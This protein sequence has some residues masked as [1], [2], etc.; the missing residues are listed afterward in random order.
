M[1]GD[2]DN[3]PIWPE[4]DVYIGTLAAV[5]PTD[6]STAWGSEWSVL[7]L[8]NGEE[9][10]TETREQE[11]TNHFA[12]GGILI[13]RIRSQHQRTFTIRALE[14]NPV[15]FSLVNPGSPEPTTDTAGLTTR[16]V[17]VPQPE[18]FKLGME[19]RDGTEVKRRFTDT[20]TA[21]LSTSEERTESQTGVGLRPVTVVLYPDADGNLY[22]ELVGTT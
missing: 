20:S 15:V 6:V 12:W 18:K 5:S 2:V 8:L 11:T 22:T 4:A 14:E 1:A 17:K 19:F 13:R 21:E 7:G 3:V 9:G 16:L 10:I